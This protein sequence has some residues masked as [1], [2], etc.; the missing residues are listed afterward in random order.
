M[1]QEFTTKTRGLA[2]ARCKGFCEGK[3]CGIT[4]WQK[5]REFDHIIPASDGGD[6]SLENCSVLCVP[7][8][9]EKSYRRDIPAIAKSNRIAAKHNG[10][11]IKSRGFAKR[12]P[13]RTASR[14][15]MRT[16]DIGN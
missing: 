12:E 14:P 4:L 7:C 1:R 10:T 16:S 9:A 8:H 3:D 2:W 5:P 15:I 6:N 13:Q 11:K